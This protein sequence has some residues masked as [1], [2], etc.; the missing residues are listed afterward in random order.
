[1]SLLDAG[2]EPEDLISSVRGSLSSS[3]L[4]KRAK[5]LKKKD[6]DNEEWDTRVVCW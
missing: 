4:I 2:T 3:D 1:M 6:G 5:R